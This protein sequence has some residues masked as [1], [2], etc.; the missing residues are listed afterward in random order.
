MRYLDFE[1][2]KIIPHPT[3]KKSFAKT[4]DHILHSLTI[5]YSYIYDFIAFGIETKEI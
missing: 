5:E 3:A 4:I 1:I 2:C